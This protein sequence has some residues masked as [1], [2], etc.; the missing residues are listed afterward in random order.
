MCVFSSSSSDQSPFSRTIIH[1]EQTAQR[2]WNIRWIWN[3]VKAEFCTIFPRDNSLC[4]L[5]IQKALHFPELGVRKV[6]LQRRLERLKLTCG[7]FCALSAA[8]QL[9][10]TAGCGLCAGFMRPTRYTTS[11]V[12][13]QSLT[14]RRVW[15]VQGDWVT[16]GCKPPPLRVSACPRA[17]R[18]YFTVYPIYEWKQQTETWH[19][20]HTLILLLMTVSILIHSS[21]G[22]RTE[23]LPWL[24]QVY[25]IGCFWSLYVF[26]A[27]LFG[28]FCSSESGLWFFAPSQG[29]S[30]SSAALQ[31]ERDT[32][33]L[34][35]THFYFVTFFKMVMVTLTNRGAQRA[36]FRLPIACYLLTRDDSGWSCSAVTHIYDLQYHHLLRGSKDIQTFY[37]WISKHWYDRTTITWPLWNLGGLTA[38]LQEDVVLSF[39]QNAA[40]QSL[41]LLLPL[42][43]HHS[44]TAVHQVHT[45]CRR[46]LNILLQLSALR[47]WLHKG[48]THLYSPDPGRKIKWW[49]IKAQWCLF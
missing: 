19:F 31:Q 16:N 34:S 36:I 33:H 15:R 24:I 48:L 39:S 9:P 38:H 47:L 18:L 44:T 43:V 46:Y 20:T 42:Q 6:G 8:L 21:A 27:V 37:S 30:V 11:S 22:I 41:A 40:G 23:N 14:Q 3:N 2:H 13:P 32:N 4:V 7:H 26:A 10:C 45:L 1:Q 17:R 28:R 49:Q 5:P 12:I 29:L 25:F 35:C